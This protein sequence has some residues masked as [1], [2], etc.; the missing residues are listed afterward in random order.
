[1]TRD[2]ASDAADSPFLILG[3]AIRHPPSALSEPSFTLPCPGIPSRAK[4]RPQPE[5]T[6]TGRDPTKCLVFC[7]GERGPKTRRDRKTVEKSAAA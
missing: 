4:S 3:L 6:K 2:S 7:A 5:E 1:M